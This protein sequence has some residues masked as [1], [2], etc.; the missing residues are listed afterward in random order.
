MLLNVRFFGVTVSSSHLLNFMRY[1]FSLFPFQSSENTSSNPSHSLFSNLLAFFI[2]S[3]LHR[4]TLIKLFET[5]RV[6]NFNKQVKCRLHES[7]GTFRSESFGL[8]FKIKRCSPQLTDPRLIPV[9]KIIA[10]TCNRI[11]NQQDK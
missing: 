3:P 11:K 9:G 5:K 4:F 1:Y 8:L 6:L 10:V 7:P 2:K